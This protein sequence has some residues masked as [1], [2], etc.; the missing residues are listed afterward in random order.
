MGHVRSIWKYSGEYRYALFVLPAV[1]LVQTVLE[2]WIPHLMGEML[3]N[4]IDA[5]SM[6]LILRQGLVMVLASL[7]MVVTGL[8][9]SRTV[10]V[11]SAGLVKNMRNDLFRRIQELAFTDTDGY[12]TAAILTRMSTDINY[13]KKG[14][15]MFHSLLKSPVMVIVTLAATVK[16]YPDSSWIFLVGSG[17][18]IVVSAIMVHF[19]LLHYRR[20]FTCYDGVNGLLEENITAQKT[21]KAFARE[22]HE[23]HRFDERAGQLRL[24]ARIAEGLTALNE[25]LLNLVIDLCILALVVLS[26]HE[27]LDGSMQTGDFF[28]LVTYANNLLFQIS[29]LAL[30]AVPLLN[31]GVSMG[32]IFEITDLTSSI[33]DGENREAGT[34]GGSVSFDHVS[35]RYHKKENG[36]ETEP[37]GD[38]DVLKDIT[39]SIRPGEFIGIIGSS[40]SGK[41]SLAG[42][43]PRFY[44]TTSG[45]V[46]VGGRDVR[47]Y[48]LADLRGRIGIVPQNSLLFSGTIAENLKWGNEDASADEIV[49]AAARA[50]ANDF[51]MQ[52]PDGYGSRVSQGGSNLSGGQRQRLCIARALI[53]RPEILILDDSLSAVDHAT[54]SEILKT[55]KSGLAGTTVILIS[56][57]FSSVQEADR[58]VVLDHGQ[59]EAVGT[60]DQLLDA[61]RV[62]QELYETQRRMME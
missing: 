58:I 19:A 23:E 26:G 45:S 61:S 6:P 1:V 21:V 41:S 39:L 7:G 47:D 11:W 31:A 3:D 57:R 56:Q 52:K 30:I 8:I 36:T 25:P 5:Q 10:A 46:T 22:E 54:E 18:L 12:G 49:T 27:I 16:E 42:L 9:I 28:C 29:M 33:V 55:L 34:G 4:G 59:I 50:C 53:R 37:D 48:T 40:G 20:M 14:M 51:V 32:R 2:V 13:V 43:I 24:E 15:G 62:Y 60:H 38:M 44:D 17:G 35:F